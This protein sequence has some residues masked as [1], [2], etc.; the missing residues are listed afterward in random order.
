MTL[1]GPSIFRTSMPFERINFSRQ[2]LLTGG[3][4]LILTLVLIGSWLSRQIASSSVSRA[5]AMSAAYVESILASQLVNWPGK[6]SVTPDI[7]EALDRVFISG[8]L[9]RKVMRF[10]LWDPDGSIAY[11]SDHTQMG[12][13]YPVKGHLAAAFAGAIQSEV[14]DLEANDNALERNRWPQLLE[15]YVPIRSADG[16]AVIAVGEFYH[17]MENLGREIRT[18][19]QRSWILLTLSACCIFGVLFGLVKRANQTIVEQQQSLRE[20]LLKTTATL[21][22]NESMR[23]QLEEAGAKTTSLNEQFLRRIAADLHD[24]PAQDL[25][26]ALLRFDEMTQSCADC[27]RSDDTPK[28]D[29]LATHG[30]LTSSLK[31]LRAI[32]SGLGVPGI[33]ALTIDATIRRAV[34]DVERKANVSIQAN[35]DETLRSEADASSL[36]VRITAYRL[37]HESLMNALRHAVGHP[38]SLDARIEDNTLHLR[39][40][41][42]GD[43]FDTAAHSDRLGLLFMRERVRLLGGAFKVDSALHQGTRIS[44]QIPLFAH[45]QLEVTHA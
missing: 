20:Q 6:G 26:F 39:I 23:L 35:L 4:I 33:D 28:R 44:A 9:H 36:A 31:E 24:G 8:P 27:P 43:G 41:D 13:N 7:H 2:F 1:A 18:A 14:S 3:V 38:P 5:T 30:A 37:V 42:D 16:K 10:K 34:R 40:T 19:Q 29:L 15:V 21:A 25:A 12:L 32:A 45:R 11:S 17:S 22:E